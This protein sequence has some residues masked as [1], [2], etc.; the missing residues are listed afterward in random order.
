M[1]DRS[2]L[3]TR[4]TVSRTLGSSNKEQTRSLHQIGRAMVSRVLSAHDAHTPNNVDAWR[5]R[6]HSVRSEGTLIN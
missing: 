2:F 4:V 5:Q 1:F 3:L 6:L